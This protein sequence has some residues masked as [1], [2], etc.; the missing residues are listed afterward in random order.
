MENGTES[1]DRANITK[2]N[3]FIFNKSQSF[4]DDLLSHIAIPCSVLPQN[5][6]SAHIWPEMPLWDVLGAFGYSHTNYAPKCSQTG[7]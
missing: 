3:Q 1:I 5:W 4:Y 7:I 2:K 6:E